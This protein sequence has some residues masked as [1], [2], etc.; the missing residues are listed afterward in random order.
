MSAGYPIDITRLLGDNQRFQR[1]LSLSHQLQ[2]Q[3]RA[4]LDQALAANKVLTAQCEQIERQK[5]G[6][7]EHFV[8]THRE[9]YEHEL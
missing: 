5:Q 9:I 3:L 2:H 1:D 6:E 8:S 4:Q 7:F